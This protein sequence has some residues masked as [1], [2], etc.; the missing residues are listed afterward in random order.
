MPYPSGHLDPRVNA[1]I[2]LL[3]DWIVSLENKTAEQHLPDPAYKRTD[4]KPTWSDDEL[5]N[6]ILALDREF[7][8]ELSWARLPSGSI[9]ADAGPGF[10]RLQPLQRLALAQDLDRIMQDH[11]KRLPDISKQ[12]PLTDDYDYYL[13][14]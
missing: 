7:D 3:E 13:N 9:H 4:N 10:H 2:L 6:L 12:L 14:G 1:V 5:N 11:P 8:K